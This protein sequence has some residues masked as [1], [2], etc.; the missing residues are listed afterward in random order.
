MEGLHRILKRCNF[1]NSD[2][3][4]RHSTRAVEVEMEGSEDSVI[5]LLVDKVNQGIREWLGLGNNQ[6]VFWDFLATVCFFQGSN[7]RVSPNYREF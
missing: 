4:R 2:T 5:Y 6:H 1:N 3:T 7:H